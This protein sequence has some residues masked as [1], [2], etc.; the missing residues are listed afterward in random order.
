MYS[1]ALNKGIEYE[2]DGKVPTGGNVMTDKSIEYVI[3]KPEDLADFQD[4]ILD[5]IWEE[6]IPMDDFS[7]NDVIALGALENGR[8][9]GALIARMYDRFDVQVASLWVDPAS[10][11]CG[12]GRGLL[13]AC[14]GEALDTYTDAYRLP[15]DEPVGISMHVDYALG[16]KYIAAFEG[17]LKETG[18]RGFK[19]TGCVYLIPADAAGVPAPSASARALSSVSKDLTDDFDRMTEELDVQMEPSLSFY[20]GDEEKPDCIILCAFGADNDFTVSSMIFD[21]CTEDVY[22]GALG[23]VFKAVSAAYPGALII[24]DSALNAYPALWSKTASE[25]G[26]IAWHASADRYVVFE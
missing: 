20:A 2:R 16:E 8:P 1:F 25:C 12:I 11:G 5:T 26:E 10:R 4:L 18:F 17:F 21:K 15:E 24:A 22:A 7:E 13:D 6:L 19:R 3:F 23:C 14:L 9:V